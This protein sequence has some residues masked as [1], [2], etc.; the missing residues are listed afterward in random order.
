MGNGRGFL[1]RE[2][3]KVCKARKPHQCHECKRVILVGECYVL[4]VLVYR[5]VT[6]WGR[7]YQ[8][9]HNHKVCLSCWRGPLTKDG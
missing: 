4:D 5:N 1:I 8:Y 9:T 7:V 2:K 6:R 3:V